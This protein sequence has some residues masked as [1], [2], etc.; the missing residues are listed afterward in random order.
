MINL[1][2]ADSCRKEELSSLGRGIWLFDEG[3]GAWKEVAESVF[4]L[5]K[6]IE[7]WL[8]EKTDTLFAGGA[9]TNPFLSMLSVNRKT[10]FELIVRDFTKLFVEQS[11]FDKFTRCGGRIKVLHKPKL[12]AVITNPVSPE[13]VRMDP[14]L[15]REQME[16][17]LQVPVYDVVNF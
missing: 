6:G 17:A 8:F 15:L 16:D 3:L 2:E 5:D 14:V 11:T 10:P 12:I 9:V 7:R 4:T 1:E 13:G